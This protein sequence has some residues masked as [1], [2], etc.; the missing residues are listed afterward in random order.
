M[1]NTEEAMQQMI[2]KRYRGH[3]MDLSSAPHQIASAAYQIERRHRKEL[4]EASTNEMASDS[5]VIRYYDLQVKLGLYPHMSNNWFNGVEQCPTTQLMTSFHTGGN[6]EAIWKQVKQELPELEERFRIH[7]IELNKKLEIEKQIQNDRLSAFMQECKTYRIDLKTYHGSYKGHD[8]LVI[9]L[10]QAKAE[11]KRREMR[12]QSLKNNSKENEMR[13]FEKR[14]QEEEKEKRYQEFKIK[15]ERSRKS[16][17]AIPIAVAV[18][19]LVVE[20]IA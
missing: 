14:F 6:K 15:K 4:E 17:E 16:T 12:K 2:N 5:D 8:Q 19:I 20:N 9:E 7:Q 13:E 18:P 1:S 3:R 11:K 10:Q